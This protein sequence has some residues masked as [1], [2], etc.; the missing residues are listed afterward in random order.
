MCKDFR[1]SF[2]F[3]CQVRTLCETDLLSVLSDFSLMTLMK[4]NV[5][6]RTHLSGK[7]ILIFTPRNTTSRL[8]LRRENKQGCWWTHVLTV[9][10]L[11]PS[12]SVSAPFHTKKKAR[13]MQF[14]WVWER[15]NRGPIQH[16]I[17]TMSSKLLVSSLPLSLIIK[18]SWWA[19]RAAAMAPAAMF[20]Q[21]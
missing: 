3:N 9:L 18:R 7:L 14:R 5:L 4:Q 17:N 20:I 10:H 19:R 16:P 21:L 15:S 11:Y 13:H 2:A 12:S 1:S 8:I 6:D